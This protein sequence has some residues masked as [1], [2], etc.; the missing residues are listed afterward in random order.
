MWS[1]H[2]ENCTTSPRHRL[3]GALQ[4]YHRA[5][6]VVRKSANPACHTDV[7]MAKQKKPMAAPV[8]LVEHCRATRPHTDDPRVRELHRRYTETD[9]LIGWVRQ[10]LIQIHD[11]MVDDYNHGRLFAWTTQIRHVEELYYRTL[12]VV[13]L[14]PQEQVPHWLSGEP[15]NSINRMYKD[16]N[17]KIS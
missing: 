13:F 1:S 5:F 9:N 14:I 17:E 16:V 3:E 7:N 10:S 6:R 11:S 15:P 8:C 2:Q 12:Y 4:G